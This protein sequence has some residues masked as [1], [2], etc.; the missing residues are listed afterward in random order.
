MHKTAY[1]H[2]NNMHKC[3]L[4][5]FT[6]QY[7]K[8]WFTS[9]FLKTSFSGKL[10]RCRDLPLIVEF[11]LMFYKDKPIDWLLDHLLWVKVCS[12]E[13]DAVSTTIINKS[14]LHGF[15]ADG[16]TLTIQLHFRT[17][18]EGNCCWLL[19]QLEFPNNHWANG[20]HEFTIINSTKFH[21]FQ[22]SHV[23]S[24]WKNAYSIIM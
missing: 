8:L 17:K 2:G 1:N 10:F 16:Q 24:L 19:T 13:K 7:G 18:R 15:G 4:L 9:P 11:L 14:K 12:P 21:K 3:I 23:T 6:V 5:C 20:Q 22:C